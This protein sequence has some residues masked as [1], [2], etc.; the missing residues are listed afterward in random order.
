MLRNV[1]DCPAPHPQGLTVAE[2]AD[3][4]GLTPDELNAAIA[5]LERHDV[6]NSLLS[7]WEN[8]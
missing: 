8:F 7:D 5:I 3:N 4:T 1:C 2:I 6:I